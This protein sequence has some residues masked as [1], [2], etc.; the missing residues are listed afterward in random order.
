MSNAFLF[1]SKDSGRRL[2]L[3]QVNEKK[4]HL[5]NAKKAYQK[6][7]DLI[8]TYKQKISSSSEQSNDKLLDYQHRLTQLATS[9]QSLETAINSIETKADS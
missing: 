9:I 1:N 2:F 5:I 4:A 3:R 8:E 6:A 7:F